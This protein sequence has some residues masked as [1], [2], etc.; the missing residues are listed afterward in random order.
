MLFYPKIISATA[1]RYNDVW[2]K[3][4]N[5]QGCENRKSESMKTIDC[6]STI[7]SCHR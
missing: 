4:K 3:H 7:K 2:L 5:R 1:T 6:E